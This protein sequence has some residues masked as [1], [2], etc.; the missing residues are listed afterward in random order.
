[1]PEAMWTGFLRLSLIL[2]PIRLA[3][4][5]GAVM[6]GHASPN[7][8][9]LTS[10][11]SGSQ[12]AAA[13]TSNVIAVEHFSPRG[14]IERAR[15][16]TSYFLYAEVSEA[17]D[18]LEALR[19]AML[20]SEHDGIGF[21]R[22]GERECMVLIQPL[23][24][25]LM[26]S[27]LR[28]PP[29][30]GRAGSSE[31]P[32]REVTGEM[33]DVAEAMI[34]R[35]R[36]LGTSVNALHDSYE[37]RQRARVPPEPEPATAAPPPEPEPS[38]E[39]AP[40]AAAPPPDPEPEPAAVPPPEPEPSRE[41]APAAA[42]PPAPAPAAAPPAAADEARTEAERWIFEPPLPGLEQPGRELGAEILLLIMGLGDRRFVE[43]GWAGHPGSRRQ[44][45]AI[46]IRPRE[47]LEPS[48][49]EFRVFAQ[50]SRATAWVSNGNYAG[51][52]GRQL[53]LTGFAVRPAAEL[54]DRFDIVYEGCFFD[55][56]VVGPKRNGD[57]C[58]SPVANDPLE[59]VRISIVERPPVWQRERPPGEEMASAALP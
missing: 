30:A 37:A 33:V 4:T 14:Q 27:T 9:Q 34:G 8:G 42:A 10:T 2:C 11:K 25:G 46:S 29:V 18:T 31:Q 49:I 5:P 52:R 51:T 13:G 54:R 47:K 35:R 3:P 41:A 36:L 19:L 40:V 48:A 24:A 7:S 23:G 32:E 20:R 58:T 50:E 55:G 38:R 26:L 45:E 16:A 39:A 21:L 44:I 17:A 6:N 59:T 15:L 57:I 53:P 12:T 1:M 43:P 56:G 28:Q 22:N